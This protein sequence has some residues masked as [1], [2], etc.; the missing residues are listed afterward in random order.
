MSMYKRTRIKLPKGAWVELKSKD[1]LRAMIKQSGRSNRKFAHDAGVNSPT[2]DHLL[3]T[4]KAA[5]MGCSPVNAQRI[6]DELRVPLDVLF[7]VHAPS[8]SSQTV[9]RKVAA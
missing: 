3:S 9:A 4:G 7:D 6:A 8:A 2:V 5:R 1:V